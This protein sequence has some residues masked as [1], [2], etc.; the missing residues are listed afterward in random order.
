MRCNLQPLLCR[1]HSHFVV[2]SPK[3]PFALR[4]R[5]HAHQQDDCN[6]LDHTHPGAPGGSQPAYKRISMFTIADDDFRGMFDRPP[7]KPLAVEFQLMVHGKL[8]GV[9]TPVS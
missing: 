8:R 1:L 3:L 2:P 7:E 5:T 6:D 4:M 9:F